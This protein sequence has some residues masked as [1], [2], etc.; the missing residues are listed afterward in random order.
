M[1]RMHLPRIFRYGDTF[2]HLFIY[3]IYLFYLF[4]VETH[5]MCLFLFF[6]Q[7]KGEVGTSQI[8]AMYTRP[9]AVLPRRADTAE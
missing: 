9:I 8:R 5:C 6:L 7:K 3:F 2:L 4:F 1:R